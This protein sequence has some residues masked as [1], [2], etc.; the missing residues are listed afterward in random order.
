MFSTHRF[1]APATGCMRRLRMPTKLCVMGLFL[2]VPLAMLLLLTVRGLSNDVEVA[3]A[4]IEGTKVVKAITQLVRDV[5]TH[6]GLTQ[7]SL[8]GAAAA[9]Q[10]LPAARAKFTESMRG[11]EQALANSA[12]FEVAD[13]WRARSATLETLAAGRHST[14]RAEAFAAHSRS[15][16]ELRQMLLLVA[17]RSGLLLDPVAESFFLMDI[18]VE[19]YVPLAE[20]L[21]VLRG[22]GSGVLA[23]GEMSSVERDQLLTRAGSLRDQM[24][25][26]HGKV[27]ALKRSGSS[28]PP[29]W[30]EAQAAAEVFV[31]KVR[32]QFG[33]DK[34]Q[35]DPGELFKQGTAAL[36]VLAEFNQDVLARLEATLQVRRTEARRMLLTVL[37]ASTMGLA[38][39]LYFTL[40]FYLNVRNA[41]QTLSHGIENVAAG[42]LEYKVEIPGSDEFGEMGKTLERMNSRLSEMV[43][44]IRSSAVRVGQAGA[45]VAQ[46]SAS[47]SQRT[48][49]QA[50]SLRQTVATVSQ[51]SAA[52]DSNADAAQSLDR[53]T[54][55]LRGKAEAGG[56]AM[57]AT[58]GAM[59][60]LVAG[61]KRMGEIIG[62]ID[63]IAFQTNI[64]ALNAAVEAARAGDAGRGFAVVASEVRHLAQRSGN[65]AGE[66]RKL[67]GQSADQVAGSVKRITDVQSTLDTVVIGVQDVSQRLRSIATASTEQ[68]SGLREMSANVGNLD[69]ITRQNAQMVDESS[70]AS[71]E[72]V[73]RA[74]TLRNAVAPMRLRQGSADE[75]RE[76]VERAMQRI[77]SVGLTAAMGEFR[78][79]ENGF[80]D[81]DMYVFIVDRSGTYRLH[82]AKPASE[83]KRVHDI[84]GIDGDRFVDDVFRQTQHRPGWVEYNILNLETGQVQAKASYVARVDDQ[85]ALGCGVYRPAV[86]ATSVAAQS[87]PA[88]APAHN[89]AGRTVP[90]PVP[91]PAPMASPARQRATHQRPPRAGRQV[92][93]GP[94]G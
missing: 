58:V 12:A 65:A 68:S 93:F 22:L 15:I 37:L 10:A 42:N 27:E 38:F 60:T 90:V 57:R 73:E 18:G 30:K 46:A 82:A 47:L 66:I 86:T 55:E 49:E 48:D 74:A 63:G 8:S 39:L 7:Q 25:N 21:G 70:V 77:A 69:E 75:A 1:L 94:A 32:A 4:E 61:S 19:R 56:E 62:V 81:R 85:H 5:Q 78:H 28:E 41:L 52:V 53:L 89:G 29:K 33:V 71:R 40:A 14:D 23:R 9:A 20:T 50:T 34:P 24:V 31:T 67:I 11:L 13:L 88:G 36:G 92:A 26:L 64:L 80:V 44:E 76:L 3:A 87:N 35:G 54:D 17:E 91:V 83:G 2:F 59:A 16:E 6:R 43:A 84:P 45:Q 72:L 51:L 79:R